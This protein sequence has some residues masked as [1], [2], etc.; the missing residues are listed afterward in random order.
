MKPDNVLGR[1]FQIESDNKDRWMVSYADLITLLLGFF[2]VMYSASSLDGNKYESL[3]DALNQAFTMSDKN[4]VQ[5]KIP[6]EETTSEKPE[7][8]HIQAQ[9]EQTVLNKLAADLKNSLGDLDAEKSIRMR[10]HTDR[11]E[12]EIESQVLFQVGQA[13]LSESSRALLSPLAEVLSPIENTIQVEGFT[14][15]VPIRT[16]RFPSNWELSAARSASVVRYFARNGIVP[17]RMSATGYGEFRPV[18]DNATPE[19]RHRNR[20]VL[21]VINASLDTENTESIEIP[22]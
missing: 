15:D 12:V 16:S 7:T 13:S 10:K 8:A 3:S 21:I 9:R 18:E 22:L 4:L 5:E 17:K 2:I 11:I 1:Y 6:L 14:D 19:G 20:R